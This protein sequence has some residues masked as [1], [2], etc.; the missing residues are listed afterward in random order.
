[1]YLSII[2]PA[3]NEE[4]R[5]GKTI[6]AINEYLQ[7]QSYSYE[8]IVSDDGSKDNTVQLVKNLGEKVEN[9]RVIDNKK[10]HGKGYVVRQNY[11]GKRRVWLVY[12]R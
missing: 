7:K 9:L 8:I 12:G 5:I 2:I 6:F 11:A 10:N 1:M 4:G 3:Y